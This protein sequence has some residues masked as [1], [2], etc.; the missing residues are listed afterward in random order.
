MTSFNL[1]IYKMRKSVDGIA[2]FNSEEEQ[3]RR[4][5]FLDKKVYNKVYQS[6]Q[7]DLNHNVSDVLTVYC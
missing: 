1:S 3:A 4:H 5:L 7:L 6:S 2:I